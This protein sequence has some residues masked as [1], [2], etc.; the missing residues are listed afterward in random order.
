MPESDPNPTLEGDV[1][2]GTRKCLME[3]E[4]SHLLSNAQVFF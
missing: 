3:L 2:R 1:I 4:M